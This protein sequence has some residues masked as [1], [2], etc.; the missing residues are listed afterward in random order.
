MGLYPWFLGFLLEG[1]R[2]IG[3]SPIFL[4]HWALPDLMELLW[5]L[6]SFNLDP[7]FGNCTKKRDYLGLM[8]KFKL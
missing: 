6:K 7:I 1:A 8:E 3:P 5:N 4:E 2:L